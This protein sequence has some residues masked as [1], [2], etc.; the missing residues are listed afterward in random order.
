M[1]HVITFHPCYVLLELMGRVHNQ[2]D[3]GLALAAL[4][5]KIINHPHDLTSIIVDLRQ[6]TSIHKT[7]MLHFFTLHRYDIIRSLCFVALVLPQ[8]PKWKDMV[9]GLLPFPD[10]LKV[11]CFDDMDKAKT[12]VLTPSPQKMKWLVDSYQKRYVFSG[13]PVPLPPP[14]ICQPDRNLYIQY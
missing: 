3:L 7:N 10:T 4:Q 12:W 5:N 9:L 14:G 1:R 8:E 2:G 11:K 6:I 13:D